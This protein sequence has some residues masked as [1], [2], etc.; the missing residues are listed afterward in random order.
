MTAAW[1]LEKSSALVSSAARAAA[2]R[3][4]VEPEPV[5]VNAEASP[6]GADWPLGTAKAEGFDANKAMK[7]ME[8]RSP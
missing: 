4:T 6:S 1:K 7:A 2:V 8:E 5:I 3:G